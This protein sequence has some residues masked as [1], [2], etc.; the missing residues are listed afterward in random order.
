MIDQLGAPGDSME[1]SG[2]AERHYAPA[3]VASLWSL[4]VETIRRIFLHEPGVV[5]L[6]SPTKKGRPSTGQSA[7]PKPFWNAF[8]SAFRGNIHTNAEPV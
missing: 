8:I 2:A 7:Y 3:E 1:V 5:V 6:Q 4:D